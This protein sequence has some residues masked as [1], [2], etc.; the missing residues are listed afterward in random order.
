L[1]AVESIKSDVVAVVEIESSAAVESMLFE[2][3]SVV[4]MESSSAV[5]SM[6]AED[7]A[8]AEMEPS[9]SAV[10]SMNF[11]EAAVVE[12]ES[13]MAVESM[14][15]EEA[16]VVEV[17]SLSAASMKCDEA[18]F[19]EE[20]ESIAAAVES[21]NSDSDQLGV[22]GMPL[23]QEDDIAVESDISLQDAQVA[24]EDAAVTISASGDEGVSQVVDQRAEVMS[25]VSDGTQD[26]NSEVST[27]TTSSVETLTRRMTCPLRS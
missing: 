7:A 16:A 10:E 22:E 19:A 18:P 1:S 21:M 24:A 14:N 27:A 4:E 17:E 5:Q 12:M 23:V 11:E 2:E 3:A 26:C 20:K 13:T 15:S 6:N 25:S 9:L 8:V